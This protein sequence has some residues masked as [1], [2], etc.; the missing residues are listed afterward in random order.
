MHALSKRTS[1]LKYVAK[2]LIMVKLLRQRS[3]SH[4]VYAVTLLLPTPISFVACRSGQ[5]SRH[6]ARSSA[7]EPRLL[8][9][10][11]I[12]RRSTTPKTCT[13]DVYLQNE[14]AHVGLSVHAP[15]YLH[16]PTFA[17]SRLWFVNA[18]QGVD[19]D[20]SESEAQVA[21]DGGPPRVCRLVVQARRR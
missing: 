15:V 13:T 14:C 6:H 21:E 12:G 18:D 1:S 9:A 5:E 17:L 7:V 2:P 19:R 11:R 4:F 20:F 16:G 8:Q 3:L 10:G